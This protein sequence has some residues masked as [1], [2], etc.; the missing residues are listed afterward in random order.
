MM[1]HLKIYD[2]KITTLKRSEIIDAQVNA[3]HDNVK[4]AHGA[5][6]EGEIVGYGALQRIQS[7]S[8][9]EIVRISPL[10]A[11]SE[12][13]GKKLFDALVQEVFFVLQFNPGKNKL[14]NV[15]MSI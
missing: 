2:E 13:I 10:Y 15:C 9:K 14:R 1:K 5:E 6:A 3:I 4:V 11:D 12:A 7:K 8:F